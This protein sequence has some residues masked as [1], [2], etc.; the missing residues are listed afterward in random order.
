MQARTER[1]HL[2]EGDKVTEKT[3]SAGATVISQ[4]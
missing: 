1:N 2:R 4:R 3:H